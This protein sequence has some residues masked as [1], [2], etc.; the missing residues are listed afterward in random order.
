MFTVLNVLKALAMLSIAGLVVWLL[1]E[2]L[3]H[4]VS[5]YLKWEESRKRRD[6]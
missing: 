2:M 1:N 5:L 3:Y 4:G 6:P